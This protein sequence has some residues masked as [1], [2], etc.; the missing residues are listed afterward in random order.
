MAGISGF[1]PKTA[2]SKPAMLPVTPYAHWHGRYG[3]EPT[4]SGFG[5]RLA[6]LEHAPVYVAPPSIYRRRGR[7]RCWSTTLAPPA[8]GAHSYVPQGRRVALCTLERF[9]M[10]FLG[11][12]YERCG[13]PYYL[14]LAGVEPGIHPRHIAGALLSVELQRHKGGCVRSAP[15]AWKIYRKEVCIYILQVFRGRV[16]SVF[17]IRS[18]RFAAVDFPATIK[19]C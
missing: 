17:Y 4:T 14:P 6:T 12:F 15:S 16:N 18:L 11:H 3:I 13:R 10:S 1:E 7:G 5:G 2:G 8:R 19:H 9:I